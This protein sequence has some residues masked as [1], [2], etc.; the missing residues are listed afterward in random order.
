MERQLRLRENYEVQAVRARGKAYKAGPIVARILARDLSAQNRYA[1]VAGKRIGNAVERNRCK[2]LVREVLREL[3]PR[4]KQGNDIVIILRGGTE[5]LPG[6]STAQEHLVQIFRRADL[7]S[8][9]D[10]VAAS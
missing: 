4:L 5:E 10:G 8:S 3:H 2:R 6:L 7:Y 9:P 1:V